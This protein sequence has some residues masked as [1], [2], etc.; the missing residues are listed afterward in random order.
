MKCNLLKDIDIKLIKEFTHNKQDL[1]ISTLHLFSEDLINAQ[2]NL[3]I[4]YI[5]DDIK[6]LKFIT[7]RIK[8]NMHLLGLNELGKLCD[9]I[10]KKNISTDEIKELCNS[11]FKSIP[12]I[13]DSIEIELKKWE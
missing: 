13:L 3:T 10:A 8:S 1:I 5:N 2:K 6:K 4:A 11:I 7:H 9:E 12:F